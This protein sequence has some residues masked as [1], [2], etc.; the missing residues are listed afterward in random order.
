MASGPNLENQLV[1]ANSEVIPV[2][3]RVLVY[4]KYNCVADINSAGGALRTPKG[5]I[6]AQATKLLLTLIEGVPRPG[7]IKRILGAV[8]WRTFASHLQILKDIMCDGILTQLKNVT[9]TSNVDPDDQTQA[10]S[11][12]MNENV[13]NLI[14]EDVLRVP[15]GRDGTLMV[16]D[17]ETQVFAEWLRKEAFRFF[18]FVEKVRIAG[19]ELERSGHWAYRNCLDPMRP[20]LDDGEMIAFFTSKV[21]SVE[22]IRNG[23]IERLFYMRPPNHGMSH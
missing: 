13:S 2:I 7:V 20:L 6:H 12:E 9:E 11:K 3:N 18:S 21:G 22:V 19:E 15:N 14:K 10:T 5:Q 17:H 16:A 1:I 8:D 4:T 23:D